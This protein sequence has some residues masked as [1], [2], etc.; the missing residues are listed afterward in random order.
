[1]EPSE[2]ISFM[3][4]T[5]EVNETNFKGEGGGIGFNVIIASYP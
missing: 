1:M 4:T 3:E 2:A 5:F